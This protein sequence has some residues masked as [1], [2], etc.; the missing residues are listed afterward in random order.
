MCFSG[1]FDG[2]WKAIVPSCLDFED[3]LFALVCVHV[4]MVRTRF[5]DCGK[6]FI[7]AG[8]AYDGSTIKFTDVYGGEPYAT[9]GTMHQ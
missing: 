9:S 2:H 4:H 5:L 6:L 1:L 3:T 8:R 7:R